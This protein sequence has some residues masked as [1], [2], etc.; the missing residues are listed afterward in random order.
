M[1]TLK[2]ELMAQA[3]MTVIERMGRKALAKTPAFAPYVFLH[4]VGGAQI[5]AA[6]QEGWE[7]VTTNTPMLGGASLWTKATV[8]KARSE[9]VSEQ[10]L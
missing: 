8:R 1:T 10:A 6:L 5:E 3:Y 9:V 7:I 2:A 4:L